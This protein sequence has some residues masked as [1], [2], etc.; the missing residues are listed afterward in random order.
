MVVKSSYLLISAISSTITWSV[1]VALAVSG[2][3]SEA[4]GVRR[5][6]EGVK[7]VERVGRGVGELR[8]REREVDGRVIAL[9]DFWTSSSGELWWCCSELG[10]ELWL[11][12]EVR[13]DVN[14]WSV[15]EGWDDDVAILNNNIQ[16]YEFI[17][18]KGVCYAEL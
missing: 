12:S 18:G 14:A 11:S 6:S 3:S 17:V 7:D 15:L 9:F 5:R 8:A 4:E 10:W 16:M 13:W 2:S 1:W